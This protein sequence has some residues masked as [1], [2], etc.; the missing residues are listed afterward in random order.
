MFT[1]FKN[2]SSN[3]LKEYFLPLVKLK[4]II[5]NF[6]KNSLTLK[7]LF[8]KTLKYTYSIKKFIKYKN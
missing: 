7:S 4:S 3:V 5:Y 6:V 8:I 2:K 1:L